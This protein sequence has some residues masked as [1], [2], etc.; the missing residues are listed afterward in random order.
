[1]LFEI[2]R[3]LPGDPVPVPDSPPADLSPSSFPGFLSPA[4]PAPRNRPGT[5]KSPTLLYI[6]IKSSYSIHTFAT[7]QITEY[8][9]L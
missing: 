3:F 1:M 8:C 7:Q 4:L 6:D 9:N 2:P 5:G